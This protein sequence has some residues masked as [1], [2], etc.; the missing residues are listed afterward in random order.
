MS[1]EHKDRS[2]KTLLKTLIPLKNFGIPEHMLDRGLIVLEE[3]LKPIRQLFEQRKLPKEGWPD[4]TIRLLLTILSAMD[5]DKDPKAARIGERE[6]RVASP[7]VS[8]LA[9]GFN[10]GVGRSGVL[11]APQPKAA[12]GSL[13]YQIT[14]R[15]AED[16][17]KKFGIE[18]I[19]DAYVVPLATGMSIALTLKVARDLTGGREV[20]YPRIDHKSPLN[21]I[22]F[23]GLHPKIIPC[24]L[25]GDAVVSDPSEI[26]SA[27]D[28]QTAAVLTTTTFFPPRQTDDV[29]AIAKIAKEKEIPHIINNAYGVQ[30]P[31]IMK[32]IRSAIFKGRVD[33][34]IQS[35]DKNFLCP[36]GGS[37]IASANEEF[38][39]RVAHSYAGRATAAPVVQFLTAILSLGENHYRELIQHQQKWYTLLK[40]E[41]GELAE[42]H[43][44][45]LLQV[46]SPI[47]LAMT[48]TQPRSAYEI[49]AKLYVSRVTGPRGLPEPEST[50]GT[51]CDVYPSQYLTINAAI[52]VEEKDVRA[53]I[54][55]LDELLQKHPLS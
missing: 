12:G 53:T 16:V 9:A 26:G 34:I 30:S 46:D 42:K 33:A 8:E 25:D 17:L 21:A 44:E 6:A 55:R 27:I 37:I 28:K 51:C 45:R 31:R 36:V 15:L 43:G 23:V 1:G 35:T 14:N 4:D 7:L 54:E 32:M 29:V 19:K 3:T 47:A 38:L 49:A 39:K 13:M 40:G 11:V 10:H 50:F 22:S 20:V 2:L 48:I 5:T 52:G 24:K 41:L 18:N